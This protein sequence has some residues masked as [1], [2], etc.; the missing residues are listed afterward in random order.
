M[1]NTFIDYNK[2]TLN[3]T[4]DIPI[5]YLDSKAVDGQVDTYDFTYLVEFDNNELTSGVF[6]INNN[7]TNNIQII[8]VESLRQNDLTGQLGDIGGFTPDNPQVN[9]L[10]II[11]LQQTFDIDVPQGELKLDVAYPEYMQDHKGVSW[12]VKNLGQQIPL[13]NEYY[14]F[15]YN[16]FKSRINGIFEIT[17]TQTWNNLIYDTKIITVT[18]NDITDVG[19]VPNIIDNI[20]GVG[21]TLVTQPYN[22]YKWTYISEN[23]PK[24]DKITQNGQGE[25]YVYW[26]DQWVESVTFYPLRSGQ[27][28]IEYPT[29]SNNSGMA[30]AQNFIIPLEVQNGLL[31]G[32]FNIRQNIDEVKLYNTQVT[33]EV[34][35][36]PENQFVMSRLGNSV[37][38]QQSDTSIIDISGNGITKI[39]TP[40][41]RGVVDITAT[42][43][44][45]GLVRTAT[46]RINVSYADEPDPIITLEQTEGNTLNTYLQNTTINVQA[47][48]PYI[49]NS[50]I[51]WV[52]TPQTDGIYSIQQGSTSRKLTALRRGQVLVQVRDKRNTDIPTAQLLLTLDLQSAQILLGSPD[53]TNIVVPNQTVRV[54]ASANFNANIGDFRW[55]IGSSDGATGQFQNGTDNSNKIFKPGLEGTAKI[56]VTYNGDSQITCEPFIV[57]ISGQKPTSVTVSPP[58][59]QTSFDTFIIPAYN[60]TFKWYFPIQYTPSVINDAYKGKISMTLQLIQ[61][62]MYA[63][64]G[65]NDQNNNSYYSDFRVQEESVV[66]LNFYMGG[67]LIAS[68]TTTFKTAS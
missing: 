47:N 1:T 61:G 36:E 7:T 15:E 52:F 68:H 33:L 3:N 23:W 40:K 10:T 39:V 35:F 29:A 66:G 17:A 12:S 62:S 49:N 56:I 60:Q 9:E 20:D 63:Q 57:T 37:T 58:E 48:Y 16:T 32:T 19:I 5:T 13:K 46:K 41:R 59:G 34:Y 14:V 4:I 18:N 44:Y 43:S 30:P 27:V 8:Q 53:S 67:E 6:R 51:E 25:V 42:F 22:T 21:V 38:W 11:S 64:Y 50:D 31:D 54:Y 26:P 45:D 24:W 28:N 55:S 65:G 2:N